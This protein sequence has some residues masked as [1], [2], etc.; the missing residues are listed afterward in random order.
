[1]R[2]ARATARRSVASRVLTALGALLIAVALALCACNVA[3]QRRA[4]VQSGR[5]AGQLELA[6][7]TQLQQALPMDASMP[8]PTQVIDGW[9][10]VGTLRI[11]SLGL[12][13]PVLSELSYPGLR[14][15]PCRYAGSAYADSMVVAAHNYAA[16]FGR[17][18]RLAYGAEVS[19]TDV[20]GNV[21]VYRVTSIETLGPY[22]VEAMTES[23][24]DLTLFT[25]TLGGA[26]RVT[27]RCERV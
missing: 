26:Y 13:L 8:M 12:E 5:V 19:F 20:R 10:Y 7:Q 25:C 22:E 2:R 11:P 24:W 21:L 3:E 1:M 4:A 9:E 15:A 16:H 18:R 14:I 17:L 23:E 6:G 27:V